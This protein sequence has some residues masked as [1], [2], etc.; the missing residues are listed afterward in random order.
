MRLRLFCPG[1]PAGG[2]RCLRQSASEVLVRWIA[3]ACFG[4]GA[5]LSAPALGNGFERMKF[6]GKAGGGMDVSCD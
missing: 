1:V 3:E 2:F 6:A 4:T 5:W